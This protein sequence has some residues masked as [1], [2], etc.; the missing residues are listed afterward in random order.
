MAGRRPM[1]DRYVQRAIVAWSIHFPDQPFTANK[2]QAFMEA[3]QMQLSQSRGSLTVPVIAN[4]LSF[5]EKKGMFGL[6]R[7]SK[8]PHIYIVK[9]EEE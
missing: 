2:L 5:W 1:F 4:R 3:N 7:L 9:E 8:N 6:V